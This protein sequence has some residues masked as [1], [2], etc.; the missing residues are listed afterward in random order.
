MDEIVETPGGLTEVDKLAYNYALDTF[1]F[2]YTVLLS[3]LSLLFTADI[4]LVGLA[5]NQK[6]PELLWLACV[7]PIVMLAAAAGV[8]QHILP[9]ICIAV[10]IEKK[11]R[12]EQGLM[13]T[14]IASVFGDKAFENVDNALM[15]EGNLSG[16]VRAANRNTFPVFVLYSLKFLLAAVL[17]HV[18]VAYMLMPA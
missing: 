3:I 14:Y 13:T 4:A 17:F 9:Y 1:R 7:V 5:V 16:K 10:S 2:L 11:Y 12:I 8:R 18:L 6:V 15:E